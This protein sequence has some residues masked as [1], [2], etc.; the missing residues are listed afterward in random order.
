MESLL[1]SANSMNHSG[2]RRIHVHSIYDIEVGFEVFL[3]RP[4]LGESRRWAAMLE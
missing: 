2:D 1:W 4:L 3:I